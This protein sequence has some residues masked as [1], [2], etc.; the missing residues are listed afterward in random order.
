MH[1]PY[2]KR[3]SSNAQPFLPRGSNPSRYGVGFSIPRRYRSQAFA[4]ATL[5]LIGLIWLLTRGGSSQHG[6]KSGRIGMTNHSPSG[7]PPAVIV[8]VLDE[9]RF[10]ARYTDLVKENRRLYAEK[11]GM[12]RLNV[13][14]RSSGGR[15]LV[16]RWKK[17]PWFI[18]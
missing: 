13:G 15:G 7:K 8:T 2:P 11:H 14:R 18:E 1:L 3:K 10:G 17:K 12:L 5:V 6:T 4:V 16:S 9:G